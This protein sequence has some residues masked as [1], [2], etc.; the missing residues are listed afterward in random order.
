V[1]HIVP[2]VPGVVRTVNK[3]LGDT[4]KKG[5]VLAVLESRELAGIQSAFLVAKERIALARKTFGREEKLWKQKI[6]SE[7]EYLNAQQQLA[8]LNIELEA[9]KQNLLSLGFDASYLSGLSFEDD[10]SLTRYDITAPFDGVV[11]ERHISIG[12]A[13]AGDSDAFRIADLS[14][15][16]V[17]LTIY[18]KD[19]SSVRAGQQVAITAREQGLSASGTI[20][21]LSPI[22]DTGTRTVTGRV[23]LENH[24]MTWRPGLFVMGA[25]ETDE[26]DVS[27]LIPRSAIV[28]MDNEHVVFLR[29]GVEFS[30]IPVTIGR[31]NVTDVEVLSGLK[32]GD[33]YVAKGGFQIKAELITAGLDSHAGHGH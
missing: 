9:A 15:V 12:E 14:T 8:E 31:G 32:S 13:V 6:S 27:V 28:M 24:D 21:Y 22:I 29:D 33:R 3:K 4:V 1:S 11:I 10:I 7:T 25:V 19:L 30:S 18:Q 20:S 17:N 23:E 2:F 16:W 5:E 26:A